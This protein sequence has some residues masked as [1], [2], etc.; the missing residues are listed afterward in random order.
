[1]ILEIL[2]LSMYAQSRFTFVVP[3]L[4]NFPFFE[5]KISIEDLNYL[6]D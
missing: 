5:M 3:R 4:D 6:T 1:M 2:I